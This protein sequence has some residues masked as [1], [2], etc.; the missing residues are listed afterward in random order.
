MFC[1]L[2]IRKVSFFGLT[3]DEPG[4]V[5]M[6]V[7]TWTYEQDEGFWLESISEKLFN[8]LLCGLGKKGSEFTFKSFV[9]QL[10]PQKVNFTN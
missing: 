8:L 10:D 1:M 5:H 3:P 4:P 7:D 6:L 9:S 2:E